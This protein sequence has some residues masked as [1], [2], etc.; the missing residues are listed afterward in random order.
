MI[1]KS[2]EETLR[3]IL[4]EMER[5]I[6]VNATRPGDMAR[7]FAEIISEEYFD[8][9]EEIENIRRM[10]SLS[11]S[12]G[13]YVDMIG[14][15]VDC[16]RNIGE[17]DDSYKDRI[18][19]QVYT[20][21]GGNETAIRLR[22]LAVPGVARVRI[23]RFSHGPGSFTLQVFPTIGKADLYLLKT[24]EAAIATA[25]DRGIYVEVVGPK[26][27]NIRMGVQIQV[28][29]GVL[30]TERRMIEQDVK[31][32]AIRY[33]NELQEGEMF[34]ANELVQR[35]MEVDEKILDMQVTRMEVDGVSRGFR[36]L[37]LE[38]GYVFGVDDVAV[39]A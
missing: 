27:R 10:A 9:Y 29:S 34:V 17:D 15:L 18:S 2:K 5:R 14:E 22:A 3:T 39:S 8:A 21:A 16:T 1:I 20:V 37:A 26:L 35:V 23:E 28:A 13:F 24:V 30:L 11:T 32:A 19:K 4:R 36:N 31:R 33:L 12:Q 38:D 6:G 25:A 7:L